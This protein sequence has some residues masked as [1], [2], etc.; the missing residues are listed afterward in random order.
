ML[1]FDA[2]LGRALQGQ[3][4]LVRAPPRPLQ[5]V[6]GAAEAFSRCRIVASGGQPLHWYSAI[7]PYLRGTQACWLQGCDLPAYDSLC[8]SAGGVS[9]VSPC[10]SGWS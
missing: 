4:T 10:C 1:V 5:R 8:N 3:T 6:R 7:Q 9:Q 2:P